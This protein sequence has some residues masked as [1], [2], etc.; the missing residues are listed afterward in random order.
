MRR[1]E[2][3]PTTLEAPDA[4][5]LT[6]KDPNGVECTAL[7]AWR[8]HGD[9]AA[10][11]ANSREATI[12]DLLA[13]LGQLSTGSDGPTKRELWQLYQNAYLRAMQ[14]PDD[15]FVSDCQ[16]DACA[17]VYAAGSASRQAEVDRLTAELAD[18]KRHSRNQRG[19][20]NRFN[21]QV[22]ADY[23]ALPL[24]HQLVDWLA[25]RVTDKALTG[26]ASALDARDK[27]LASAGTDADRTE[28]P[29]KDD[30]DG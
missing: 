14:A 27:A 17:V 8:I 13:V 15:P 1:G 11:P 22:R 2:G 20:L 24:R 25:L 19:E 6:F 3:A 30:S 21:R 12:A 26:L 4:V 28:V 10:W 5:T 7:V 29:R 18:E 9:S 16:A 23:E